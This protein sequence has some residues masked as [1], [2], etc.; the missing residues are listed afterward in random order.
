MGKEKQYVILTFGPDM[1]AIGTLVGKSDDH[2]E[3]SKL[4]RID[5]HQHPQTKQIG[6]T[7][8]PFCRYTEDPMNSVVKVRRADFLFFYTPNKHIIRYFEEHLDNMRAKM[9][10]IET[11]KNKIV[12]LSDINK[13]K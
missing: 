4:H 6:F 5:I 9:S 11:K 3:V 10:G 13:G 8:T 2:I 7:W 12:T 1:E